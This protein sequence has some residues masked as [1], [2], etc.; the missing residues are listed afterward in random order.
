VLYLSEDRIPTVDDYAELGRF[1]PLHLSM[2]W[3]GVQR[4]I[5]ASPLSDD[6]RRTIALVRRWRIVEEEE[7]KRR[8]WRRGRIRKVID[9]GNL[10]HDIF[11]RR[12]KSFALWWRRLHAKRESVRYQTLIG[13]K[14]F[15]YR[16]PKQKV[17][18]SIPPS[19]FERFRIALAAWAAERGLPDE[20]R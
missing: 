18:L 10:W 8:I 3:D 12:V 13:A 15:V 7:R 20:P 11:G 16:K 1:V 9:R 5:D 4:G 19:T 17:D 6:M 14:S 2:E